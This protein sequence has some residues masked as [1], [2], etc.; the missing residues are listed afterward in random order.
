MDSEAQAPLPSSMRAV[1]KPCVTNDVHPTIHDEKSARDRLYR[2]MVAI[3]FQR[4][5]LVVLQ[6]D[7]VKTEK[8]M[9]AT[10]EY[11]KEMSRAKSQGKGLMGESLRRLVYNARG[12]R[13]QKIQAQRYLQITKDLNALVDVVEKDCRDDFNLAGLENWKREVKRLHMACRACTER[14]QPPEVCPSPPQVQ[15]P[16]EDKSSFQRF[17]S[18]QYRDCTNSFIQLLFDLRYGMALFVNYHPKDTIERSLVAHAKR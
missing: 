14:V 7:F 15:P 17:V 2:E 12:R 6:Q 18:N 8:E 10:N 13:V 16:Q 9:L 4:R 5:H 3:R 11:F 1:T